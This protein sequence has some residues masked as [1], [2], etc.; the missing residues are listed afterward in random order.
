MAGA[1]DDALYSPGIEPSAASERVEDKSAEA[2]S[3]VTVRDDED[4]A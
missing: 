3:Q 2:G 4:V 1:D